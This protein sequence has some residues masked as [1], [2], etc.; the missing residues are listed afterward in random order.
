MGAQDATPDREEHDMG[1]LFA[2]RNNDRLSYH[3]SPEKRGMAKSSGKLM[4]MGNDRRNFGNKAASRFHGK[5]GKSSSRGGR[6]AS[7]S[8]W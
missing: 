8:W 7:K 3:G 4:R 5:P 1:W 6:P 2:D